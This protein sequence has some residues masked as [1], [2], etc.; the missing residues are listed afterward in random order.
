MA[1]IVS[2]LRKRH[3][4]GRSSES[5]GEAM[6]PWEAGLNPLWHSCTIFKD[7]FHGQWIVGMDARLLLSPRE[8]IIL[9]LLTHIVVWLCL[10]ELAFVRLIL[11]SCLNG[12]RRD[13][14]RLR[15][16]RV[17]ERNCLTTGWWVEKWLGNAFW[18]G[19]LV[20]P[21]RT[22]GLWEDDDIYTIAFSVVSWKSL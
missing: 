8:V 16:K 12:R 1:S 13:W 17:W 11:F 7:L 5:V 10:G 2:I 21:A 19:M 14:G 4:D 3:S 15:R 6:R 22:A 20:F 9:F 18:R